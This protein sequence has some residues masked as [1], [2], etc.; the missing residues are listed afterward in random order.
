M[1]FKNLLII[2][3]CVFHIYFGLEARPDWLCGSHD[4]EG[5][6]Y[7]DDEDTINTRNASK[8][9]VKWFKGS[10]AVLVSP[11][12]YGNKVFYGD[13]LGVVRC[14]YA[15]DGA[16]VW[17]TPV[18]TRNVST[19]PTIVDETVYTTC[20]ISSAQ[21]QKEMSHMVSLK[22]KS[23]KMNW[24]AYAEGGNT[25]PQFEHAPTVAEDVLI[26]G[27]SSREAYGNKNPFGFEGGVYAFDIYSGFLKWR[28]LLSDITSGDGAGVGVCS[29]AAIDEKLGYAFVVSGHAYEEPASDK[30][31]SLI[32]L[33]YRTDKR[34]GEKVWSYSF[35]EQGIWNGQTAG[36]SYWGLKGIPL[37]FKGDGRR[38]VGVCDNQYTFH[39]FDRETGH[40]LWTAPLLPEGETA[41]PLG[42]LGVAYDEKTLYAAS[43]SL[44]DPSFSTQVFSL[45]LTQEKEIALLNTL[46][47]EVKS[48][49]SAF[50]AKSGSILWQNRFESA[51]LGTPAVANKLVF[52]A[53]FNGYFRV[54]EAKSGKVLFEFQSGPASGNYGFPPYNLR[55]PFTSTPAI[56]DGRIFLGGGF[57]FPQD[58]KKV[59]SGG[60]YAFEAPP[61]EN[62]NSV[63]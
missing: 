15:Q 9:F 25:V 39:A 6:H 30:S 24:K 18:G 60:L 32:C 23:G 17:N 37:I 45:P 51:I 4:A 11:T 46:N 48:T 31:C 47:H 59:V 16:E 58:S 56:S 13:T 42:S 38:L 50:K 41:F 19:S 7:Q 10:A 28:Y 27:S 35:E 55:V 14:A 22:R 21:T 29:S 54:L 26:L 2:S 40:L 57:I 5:T 62:D 20:P 44:V 33:N 63:K 52:A 3:L 49:I 61:K 34:D 12:V 43:N 36:G 1:K 53:F 8:L